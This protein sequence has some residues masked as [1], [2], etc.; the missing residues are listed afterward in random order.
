MTHRGLTGR[1]VRKVLL[2]SHDTYG[3]GHLRRNLRIASHLQASDPS[4]RVVLM[5]GS[6]VASHF[7]VPDG[8][9]LVKLPSVTKTGSEQYQP[10]DRRLTLG[11][12]RRTRTA[13]MC[14]VVRRFRPDVLLVDHSPAGMHGELLGVFDAVRVHSPA[15][16]LVLGLRDILD[17]PAAV[18]TTW[19]NQGIYGLLEDVYHQVVVY[20]SQDLF[21]VGREYLLP[22]SVREAMVYCGYLRPTAAGESAT[23]TASGQGQPTLLATAGGGGDGL[24]VLTGAIDAG[25]RLGLRTV[26]V[27][28][29]LM[30]DDDYRTV[31]ELA[32]RHESVEVLRFHPDMPSA[33]EAARLIVT[34]G[35]YNTLTEAVASGTPTIVVPRRHP[36]AEQ[37]IRADLFAGQGLVGVVDSGPDLGERIARAASDSSVA[38][39][40]PDH[41][42]FDGLDRLTRVLTD[43]GSGCRQARVARP[44]SHQFTAVGQRLPA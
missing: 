6:P 4:L 14:D 41:L 2:Y 37:A 27:T 23:T 32:A 35:G 39:P 7:S 11:V 40:M 42:D 29:P 44:A 31:E 13:V 18:T 38:R 24:A 1:P 20:G 30:N 22:S 26:A 15:T 19:R 8:L 34:M 33:M 43:Q 10:L 17:D 12:V 5:S 9:S 25:P 16:R 28:G 36:R 21:D 3:L